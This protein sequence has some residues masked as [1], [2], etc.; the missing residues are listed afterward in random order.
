[1]TKIIITGL[2]LFGFVISAAVIITIRNFMRRDE[3]EKNWNQ[4][5]GKI[6]QKW[7]KFTQDELSKIHG[8]YDYFLGL[9]QK[10]YG[11]SLSEHLTAIADSMG[12]ISDSV[13]ELFNT[14]LKQPPLFHI[15]QQGKNLRTFAAQGHLGN[16]IELLNLRPDLLNDI[17]ASQKRTELHWAVANNHTACVQALLQRSARYDM[18]D[19]HKQ[20]PIDI[21][22]TQSNPH[23]EMNAVFVTF[24]INKFATTNKT[25]ERAL[26][27]A[28]YHGDLNAVKL[29]LN[30]GVAIDAW[31][32]KHQTALHY[33]TINKH[34]SVIKYL[35]LHG[36]DPELLDNSGHHALS[37]TMN[38]PEVLLCF[39]HQNNPTLSI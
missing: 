37:Y 13:M 25:G 39:E 28:A 16:M 38:D 4:F 19:Q 30:S 8:K 33:A 26:R 18:L 32:D 6:Q 5:K 15:N 12:T 7:S 23:P 29:L 27:N 24:F 20:T 14:G 11:P 22:L 21:Y 3:F 36:A 2:V 9:L 10:K 31:N 35:V 17:A 34:L 1:M